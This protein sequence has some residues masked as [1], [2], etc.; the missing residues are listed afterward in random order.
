LTACSLDPDYQRPDLP[1][2]PSYPSGP[3]YLKDG[4]GEGRDADPLVS[5]D[6]I[7]WRD[8]FTDPR[9]Q[10]LIAIAIEQNRDLRVAALN[11]AQA[12]AQYRVQRADLFPSIS[13]TANPTYEGLP[14]S[15]NIPQQSG[16]PTSTSA[17][18]TATTQSL[19]STGSS[20]GT[21]RYYT[22]NLGFTDFELDV[23]GRIRSLSRADFET[24]L[25]QEQTR[26]SMQIS[27]VAEVASAYL[28]YLADQEL[29]RISQETA[30]SQADSY[31]LTKMMLD[32]GTTTRLSLRQ[33]EQSLDTANANLAQY[34]R[35]VAQD[36]NALTLLLGEP[37]P[38]DL[39][40][41][42]GLLDQG[43]L[44]NLPAGLPSDLLTRRPDIL[45]AEH[46]LLAANANIGAARA[47]FFPS[48]TMT[49]SAGVAS[50]Q[51]NNLFTAGATTWLFSPQL[52]VPIFTWGKNAGN[53]DYA[54][55][56]KDIDI[57]DYE[58]AIQTAFREVADALAARGT[59]GDQLRAE[60]ALIVAAS[61]SYDLAQ[62]RFRTGVDSFLAA[63]DS[64]R[65]LYSAQL[66]LVTI[67][68]AELT[69][70]VTLYKVLGGG[71]NEHGRVA[72]NAAVP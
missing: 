23:F 69:N 3:A 62:M 16:V 61:D 13:A 21:Y 44:A 26:R 38:A 8:F 6:A 19:Q 4:K 67:K 32:A 12:Q 1:T 47:A 65:T 56:Q 72:T 7:G 18:A 48:I 64:Q 37:I 24:Y 43:L 10:S 70:L 60:L 30:T 5:A 17:T 2:A 68:Q 28:T 25:A 34:T 20:G 45:A 41:G 46:T 14:N 9:L 40:S 49:A 55:L 52:N 59:Y 63:L 33:V 11:I 54:K 15:T 35:Q 66:T 53:L 29:L 27:L 39:P 58:K 31:R 36:E 22:A 51:L 71:W 50:N 42:N 57:A